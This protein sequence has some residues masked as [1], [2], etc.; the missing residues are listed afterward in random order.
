MTRIKFAVIIFTIVLTTFFS[1]LSS[2]ATT[3]YVSSSFGS[4]SNNGTSTDTPWAYAPGMTNATGLPASKTLQPGDQVLFKR[5]DIWTDQRITCGQSGNADTDAGRIYYGAYGTGNNPIINNTPTD[6]V[7]KI[8]SKSYIKIENID[9]TASKQNWIYIL[10]GNYITISNCDGG[11]ATDGNSV[12]LKVFS[13]CGH[14]TFSNCK[15]HGTGNNGSGVGSGRDG[16]SLYV[17]DVLFEGCEIY[18]NGAENQEVAWHNVYLNCASDWIFR[19]CKIHDTPDQGGANPANG[20]NFRTDILS[21]IIEECEIYN[22]S[23]A[24]Y[25]EIGTITARGCLIYNN[26]TNGIS[27]TGGSYYVYNNTFVNNGTRSGYTGH[28]IV[29][30]SGRSGWV[31]KNNIGLQD[32]NKIGSSNGAPLRVGSST[33][34]ASNTFD[35]NDWVFVGGSGP[36][37]LGGNLIS[38][39]TWQGYTGP[40]GPDDHGISSNPLFVTDYTD[41]HLKSTSPCIGKGVDVKL[42]YIGTAPDLGA[43]EYNPAG[44][45]PKPPTGLTVLSP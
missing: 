28:G 10:D 27:S 37:N 40:G 43:Y 9:T 39:V 31:I 18:N 19:R 41:L 38:F 35:Y 13:G 32:I 5:G 15:I 21:I 26:R 36:V 8:G 22:N 25:S 29:V 7:W 20:F 23:D 3:Y 2:S 1:V 17:H 33:V 42:P 14:I 4:D 16:G 12:Q 11:Y 6:Q 24:I 44:S 34:I 45:P 30:S